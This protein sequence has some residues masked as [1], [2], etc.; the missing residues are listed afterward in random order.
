MKKVL[1]LFITAYLIV[2]HIHCSLSQANLKGKVIDQHSGEVLIGATVQ[3]KGTSIGASTDLDGKYLIKDIPS[4]EHELIC[5]FLSYKTD[6]I[7][8]SIDN[9]AGTV[10]QNFSLYPE[11]YEIEEEVTITARKR[12]NN[13]THIMTMKR[14]SAG[15]MDGISAAE[16]QQNGDGN[17][18]GA[19]K[20]ISGVSVES[21]KYVYVR[22][23]SDR[24][25]KRS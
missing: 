16:I 4:G 25:S 20:R 3:L 1:S 19:V 2:F 22:G 12:N 9:N 17:A 7:Q 10:T 18:A 6:T 21:G 24:Y 23:L 13:A 14:K 5:R 11:S 8:I 15:V